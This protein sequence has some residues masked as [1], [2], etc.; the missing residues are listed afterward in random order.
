MHD[1]TWEHSNSGDESQHQKVPDSSLFKPPCA[2]VEPHPL[3]M[4]LQILHMHDTREENPTPK[5]HHIHG[6]TAQVKMASLEAHLEKRIPM[7]RKEIG[8]IFFLNI[9]QA[10]RKRMKRRG[11]R[12]P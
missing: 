9:R 7:G 11:R 5:G 4:I 1:A 2:H 8:F 12:K 3:W 6:T 10:G